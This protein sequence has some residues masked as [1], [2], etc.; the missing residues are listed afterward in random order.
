MPLKTDLNV[1]PYYDDFDPADNFQQQSLHDI[2]QDNGSVV[3][4][5]QYPEPVMDGGQHKQQRIIS[6]SENCKGHTATLLDARSRTKPSTGKRPK[7]ILML[8]IEIN[9][10]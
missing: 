5:P 1:T 7:S 4:K 2:T 3:R 8:N 6:K 9:Q 10:K